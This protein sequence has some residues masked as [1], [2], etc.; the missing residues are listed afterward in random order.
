VRHRDSLMRF[1][2]D[3]RAWRMTGWDRC[4]RSQ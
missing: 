3:A 2:S 4:S 1:R